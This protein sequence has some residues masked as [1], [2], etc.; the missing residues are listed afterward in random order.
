M[1]QVLQCCQG[2]NQT[3]QAYCCLQIHGVR[4]QFFHSQSDQPGH[5]DKQTDIGNIGVSIRV[6]LSTDLNETDDGHQ[7]TQEKQPANDEPG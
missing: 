2:V 4:R 6:G 5:A 7:R 3:Q 1:G